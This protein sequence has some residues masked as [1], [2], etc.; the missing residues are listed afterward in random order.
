M[1]FFDSMWPSACVFID[2]DDSSSEPRLDTV[3]L[4]LRNKLSEIL[5][6]IETFSFKKMHLKSRPENVVHFVLASMC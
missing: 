3:N 2:S 5:I 6:A 4:T 1:S